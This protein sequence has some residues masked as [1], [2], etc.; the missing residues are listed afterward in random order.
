MIK[1]NQAV[2]AS[3]VDRYIN[4][5][6]SNQKKFLIREIILATIIPNYN[7]SETETNKKIDEAK[8]EVA[9]VTILI[10]KDEVIVPAGKILDSFDIEKLESVGLKHK[11]SFDFR[12]AGLFILSLIVVLIVYS[13]F[14][15]FYQ[16]SKNG[17]VSRLKAFYVFVI[18]FLTASLSFF[19]LI[20]LKPIMAYLF[21]VAAFVILISILTNQQAGL[22]SAIIFS[23]FL[24]GIY[25]N[26]IELTFL[27]L[28][29]AL[30]GIY[31]T[32]EVNKIMDIFGIGFF[33][34]FFAFITSLSFHLMAESFSIRTI[35]VL[36]G[37]LAIY[38]FSTSVIIFGSL[39][40][41]GNIFRITTLLDLLELENPH[42]EILRDF[43]IKAPG[44]YQHSLIV[45]ILARQAAKDVGANVILCGVGALYHD[46]GKMEQPDYFIEN[47]KK[48]NIHQE[49]KNPE[50][51]AAII[52]FHV[53]SGLL[54]GR[55]KRLPK[56]IL[57]IIASHH[58][59]SEV[60]Y[61]L[62][63]ALK[64]G[65]KIDIKKFRYEGPLPQTKEEVVIMLSDSIEAR[66]RTDGKNMTVVKIAQIVD[67]IVDQRIKSGQ[68]KEIAM[69]FKEIEQLRES[70]KKILS[71]MYH[72]RIKYEKH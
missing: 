36:L 42:Q 21:P 26:S 7:Y 61:F 27:Y 13:Y 44:T 12:D 22:F 31:R 53:A 28:I 29:T 4:K 6:V 71:E 62:N 32:R 37:A 68:F 55:K 24:G 65:D 20:P 39:M 11:N 16:D 30:V 59:N 9:P 25:Y 19:L 2:E 66:T 3:L 58:G 69:S 35:S 41:W 48:K 52:K 57:S 70:F 64:N 34:I 33:L 17:N 60:F 50:K 63:Q 1:N 56:E 5:D 54:L 49:I 51:S 23:T 38:G 10:T 45:S 46:I 15:F 47:Q 72:K 14:N 8:Q 40:L 43:S 67:D 18:L